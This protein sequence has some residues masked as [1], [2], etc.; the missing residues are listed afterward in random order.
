[1]K[2]IMISQRAGTI[3]CN[4]DEM[5]AE[6]DGYLKDYSNVVFTEDK[7]KEAKDTVAFLRK[8]QKEI[9]AVIKEVSDA[10]NAPLIEWK[11]QINERKSRYDVPIVRI[12]EQIEAFEE[13]RKEEKDARIKEIF[14]EMVFES[15]ILAFLPLSRVYNAKWLN[16]TYTEKQI[17]DDIMLAKT[18]VKSGVNTIKSFESDVEDKALEVFKETLNLPDALKVITDYEANKK[19][20][21][22]QVEEEAR[23]EVIETFIPAETTEQ[24]RPILYTILLTKDAKAK[25]EAFMDSVGIEYIEE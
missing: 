9:D 10:W 13:S 2:E 12:N 15:D 7:K 14:G 8:R 19:V 20:F 16:A 18:N 17:K 24:T 25:L 6:I 23:A 21:K 4:F 3:T 5:D 22:K 11:K 1:M